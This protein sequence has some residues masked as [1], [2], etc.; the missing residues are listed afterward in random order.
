MTNS[1]P[2]VAPLGGGGNVGRTL[3]RAKGASFRQGK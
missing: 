3:I 2:N 1:G